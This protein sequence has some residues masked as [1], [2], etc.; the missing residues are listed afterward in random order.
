VQKLNLPAYDFN[1]KQED[2]RKTIY[3]PFRKKHVLLT[4]E[5]WVRQSFARYLTEEKGYPASL[6]MT[7]FT[8]HLNKMVKRCDL[9]VHKPAGT[10]VVLIECKAPGISIKGDTFDQVSRYN[11]VFRVKYLFVTNGL[12]HFG[13][14]I[15]FNSRSVEFLRDIPVYGDLD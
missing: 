14:R 6:M 4:P 8:L 3:D 12:Q 7:E 10:P 13:C 1:I 9:V 11:L 5:E 15:D 2:G